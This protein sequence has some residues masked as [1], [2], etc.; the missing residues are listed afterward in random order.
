MVKILFQSLELNLLIGVGLALFV[1]IIFTVINVKLETEASNG[2]VFFIFLTIGFSVSVYA[3]L[4]PIW[5][6]VIS[7]IFM[8]FIIVFTLK[9]GGN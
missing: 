5:Y 3:G 1:A 8:I 2:I 6:W 9:S 4:V 7:A